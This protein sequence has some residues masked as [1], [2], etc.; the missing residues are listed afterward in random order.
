MDKAGETTDTIN[1]DG[2]NH[3]IIASSLSAVEGIA[4]DPLGTDR[5][6]DNRRAE[7]EGRENLE[8]GSTAH[9]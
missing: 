5:C 4:L 9:T 7:A 1:L 2:S 3:E 6:R 8:P